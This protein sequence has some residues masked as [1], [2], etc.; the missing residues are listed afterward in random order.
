M[1]SLSP[2]LS[3]SN[4]DPSSG[5]LELHRHD[6]NNEEHE[7]FLFENY[8]EEGLGCAVF[9]LDFVVFV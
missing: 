7:G 9:H 5:K 6:G 2:S 8:E 4:A 3:L 1:F